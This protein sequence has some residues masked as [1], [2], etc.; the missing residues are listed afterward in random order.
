MFLVQT[1]FAQTTVQECAIGDTSIQLQKQFFGTAPKGI[2]FINLHANETTSID[3]TNQYLNKSAGCFIQLKNSDVRNVRFT[4][5]NT[6]F[7]VDPNRIFTTIG[8]EATLKKNSSYT[9]DAAKAVTGFAQNIIDAMPE[10]KLII[11]MHNNTN[12]DFSISSY[13]RGK[14][15]AINAAKLYINP[16]MD[17]DD[18]VYT[19]ELKIFNYLKEKK[20][21]VVLQKSKGFKDDGSLSVYCSKQ[22]IPYINIEAQLDH[23]KEQLQMLEA[24]TTVV[25]WYK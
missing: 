13:N 10:P 25:E 2:Y 1:T 18:F 23:L 14:N 8:I 12:N 5:N 16:T 6:L 7:K 24:I 4:L 9:T 21:N 3:A 15:E 22:S 11:A 17:S 19:T 20:I